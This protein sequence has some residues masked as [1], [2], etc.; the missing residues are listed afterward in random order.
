MQ[1]RAVNHGS[2]TSQPP[3]AALKRRQAATSISFRL[4]QGSR[5]PSGR[6]QPAAVRE[7]AGDGER[8]LAPFVPA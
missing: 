4:Y 8:R 2:Q 6:P 5:R 1:R 3:G 7:M